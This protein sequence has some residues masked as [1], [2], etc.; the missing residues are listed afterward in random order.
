MV[1]FAIIRDYDVVCMLA[2]YDDIRQK[3]M[4]CKVSVLRVSLKFVYGYKEKDKYI[5]SGSCFFFQFVNIFVCRIR[6]RTVCMISN[7]MA[8]TSSEHNSRNYHCI[9]RLFCSCVFQSF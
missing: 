2:T 3:P 8:K 5:T 4:N 1:Q 9:K 6:N 7:R